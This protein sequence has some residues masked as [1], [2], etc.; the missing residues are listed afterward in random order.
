[1][2][3]FTVPTKGEPTVQKK[4]VI[5]DTRKLTK[6]DLKRLKK[7]DPFLYF[8]IPTVRTAALLNRDV[9]LKA[10]Q[11]GQHSGPTPATTVERRSCISFECHTDLLLEDRF[12]EIAEFDSIIHQMQLLLVKTNRT[13]NHAAE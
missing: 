3:T 6:D 5:I 9:D 13:R 8:S 1:M 10:L 12:D 11:G 2:N 4:K 7:Q